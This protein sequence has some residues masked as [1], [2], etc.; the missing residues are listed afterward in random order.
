MPGLKEWLAM[1]AFKS[2]NPR[3][4]SPAPRPP[5]LR[6]AALTSLAPGILK[7]DPTNIYP[8][9][10]WSPLGHNREL[11][12]AKLNNVVLNDNYQYYPS[13]FVPPGSRLHRLRLDYDDTLNGTSLTAA[14]PLSLNWKYWRVKGDDSKV[15]LFSDGRDAMDWGAMAAGAFKNDRSGAAQLMFA[16]PAEVINTTKNAYWEF[17]FPLPG[18][19]FTSR[20][21]FNNPTTTYT[22]VGGT[23]AQHNLQVVPTPTRDKGIQFRVAMRRLTNVSVLQAQ[24]IFGYALALDNV[25]LSTVTTALSFGS[26]DISGVNQIKE[27]EEIM[28]ELLQG[29]SPS[30]NVAGSLPTNNQKNP[31]TGNPLYA[32]GELSKFPRSF[33]INFSAPQTVLV[34]FYSMLEPDQMIIQGG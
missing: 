34:S 33:Q 23:S 11:A 6:Q 29:T 1:P 13:F 26:K 5:V 2:A 3:L 24:G 9:E 14:L 30:G 4:V 31:L 8:V 32:I 7:E 22:I 27:N 25:E 28:N 15:A 18:N 12:P 19:A 20:F 10:T 16:D 21:E 17:P